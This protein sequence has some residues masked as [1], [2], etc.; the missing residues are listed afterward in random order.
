MAEFSNT[1]R[2][3]ALVTGGSRGIGRAI[4]TTLA[5]SG[6][7]VMLTYASN[8]EAARETVESIQKA[9]G[10]ANAFLLDV[11][12][13]KAVKALFDAEIK[14]KTTL[15]A[16]VNNAGITQD[17]L[18]IRMK[19]EAFAKVIE[20]DLVGAFTCIREAA[21]LMSRQRHGRIVN[22]TSIVGQ[23]GNPGQ[24]NYSAA[25]AGLIGLTKTCA[26]ELASR[27]ITVN[28]IAPGFIETDM[29][30]TLS[31]DIKAQYLA[32][33]PLKRFGAPEEV[34]NLVDFLLSEKAAYITGQIIGINGGL[35][36]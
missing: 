9:G 33:I 30:K 19:D 11:S 13:A 6:Y 7:H 36:G 10:S 8:P 1:G 5:R 14:D 29:T 25:K 2:P 16:L 4:A 20:V 22:I 21:K 17:G 3:S 34:A 27:Q 23:T 26:R 35:S 31:E 15:A 32:S 24:A 28:A 18:L 12:D